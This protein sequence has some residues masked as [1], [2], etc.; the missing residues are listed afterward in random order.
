MTDLII[1]ALSGSWL[2]PKLIMTHPWLISMELVEDRYRSTQPRTPPSR[3]EENDRWNYERQNK[4]II[5]CQLGGELDLLYFGSLS[6][7]RTFLLLPT[8]PHETSNVSSLTKPHHL[9][10]I[11]ELG[12]FITRTWTSQERIRHSVNYHHDNRLRLVGCILGPWN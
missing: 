3:S 9:R 1:E 5:L 2:L 4:W 7:L 10:S 12:L 8:S 6:P 11:T